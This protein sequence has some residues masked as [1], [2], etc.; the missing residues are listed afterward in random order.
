MTYQQQIAIA[1]ELNKTKAIEVETTN[2][3]ERNHNM[4]SDLASC[5]IGVRRNKSVIEVK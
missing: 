4:D 2:A 5:M 1:R 3:N